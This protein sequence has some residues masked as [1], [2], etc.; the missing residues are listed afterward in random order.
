M[1]KFIVSTNPN[2][3]DVDRSLLRDVDREDLVKNIIR[4]G[5]EPMIW[6]G[7]DRVLTVWFVAKDIERFENIHLSNQDMVIPLQRIVY[8][9]ELW[10]NAMTLWRSKLRYL[11]GLKSNKP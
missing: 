11:Q 6:E 3:Q 7:D 8:A 2:Y 9:D 10:R 4:F 5:I 1:Q